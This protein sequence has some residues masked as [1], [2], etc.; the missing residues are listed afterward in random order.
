V[1]LRRLKCFIAVAECLHFGRAAK[2]LHIVQSA[3]SQQIKVLE[4]EL[5]VK[6]LKRSRHKVEL[7]EAGRVML[8]E[9][10]R[11]VQQTQEAV[12]RA[13]DAGAGKLGRLRLGFVDNALWAV[14]PPILRT[15]RDRYPNVDLSLQQLDRS[16]Q[17]QALEFREIDIGVLPAPA[18]ARGF[19]S[20]LLIGAPLVL[21]LPSGHR[22]ARRTHV[23]LHLLA[24]EAF[25]SFPSSMN[26]RLFEMTTAACTSAGFLPS[27]VQEAQQLS[28]LL[29]LVS[30]GIGIT[31]VPNWVAAPHPQGIVYREIVPEL[32]RYE[33]LLVWQSGNRDS[34]LLNFR[35]VVSELAESLNVG[36]RIAKRS[37]RAA[38][39]S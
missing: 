5:S 8:V 38:Q 30:S 14:L 10:R 28:T 1:E 6:L 29:A 21:A 25:V 33:L 12:R 23:P 22:L 37:P 16:Q 20:E 36:H 32:P 7:T 39:K 27:V 26:T 9:A 34:A 18:P 13:Q 31:L 24:D 35:G 2:R 3:V 15:F 11:V 17:I 19:E 4:D